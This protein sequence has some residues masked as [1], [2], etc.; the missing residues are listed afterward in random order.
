VGRLRTDRPV[1]LA[2][3][4]SKMRTLAVLPILIFGGASILYYGFLA[5]C[6]WKFYQLFSTLNVNIDAIRQALER[7]NETGR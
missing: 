4:V 7:N 2:L 1:L 3:E 6:A 5:F